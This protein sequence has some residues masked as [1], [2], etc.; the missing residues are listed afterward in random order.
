MLGFSEDRTVKILSE[1]TLY[2]EEYRSLCAVTIDR[3]LEGGI[4]QVTNF[5]LCLIFIGFRRCDQFV[6][7]SGLPMK[8]KF[9]TS[10]EG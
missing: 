9:S 1:I 2:D 3:P 6:L 7:K 4:K 10:F 5:C 8:S